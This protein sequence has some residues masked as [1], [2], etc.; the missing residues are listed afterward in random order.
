MKD[1]KPGPLD[2]EAIA[3]AILGF[4]AENPDHLGRFLAETGLGPHQLRGL[5][6]DRAFLVGLLDFLMSDE[7]LLLAFTEA[8]NV[9]PTMIAIARHHLEGEIGED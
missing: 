3:A 5:A 2:A 8:A 4:L 7:S 9:R 1:R 6:R